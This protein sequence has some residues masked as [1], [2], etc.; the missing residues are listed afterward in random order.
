MLYIS[1]LKAIAVFRITDGEII[2]Q[3][4][5]ERKERGLCTQDGIDLECWFGLLL[6]VRLGLGERPFLI[7]RIRTL[8]PTS[9]G[10]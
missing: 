3:K 6:A 8:G 9:V 4:E 2:G 1:N 5:G 10:Y 7:G